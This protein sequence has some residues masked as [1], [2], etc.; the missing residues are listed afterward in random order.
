GASSVSQLEDNVAALGNLAFD[1]EE[2]A[3]IDGHATEAG[4]NLWEAS[5][6]A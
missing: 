2:L 3:E 6:R 4:I 5:S 1:D